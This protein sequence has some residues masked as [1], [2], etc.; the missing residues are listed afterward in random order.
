[1][2]VIIYQSSN[3]RRAILVKEV[4]GYLSCHIPLTIATVTSVPDAL[5]KN[6]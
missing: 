1:M 5:S 2:G 4:R 6:T 3:I